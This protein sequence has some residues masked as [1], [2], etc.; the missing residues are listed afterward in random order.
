[1][2]KLFW[3]ITKYAMRH[4]ML[5]FVAY[6][7]MTGGIVSLLVILRLL[8]NA[9]DTTV[10]SGS[11]SQL[12]IQ[13]A[14]IVLAAGARGALTYIDEYSS[15]V[16]NQRVGREI[17]NDIFQKLQSLSYGFHDRQRTGD[18]MSRATV[19]VESVQ[20]F[21]M[22]GLGYFAYLIILVG[23]ASVLMLTMNLILGT[24]TMAFMA[25]VVWRSAA[26]VPSMVGLY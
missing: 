1:M 20:T 15:D 9:I 4:K 18:L 2:L 3:R 21:P 25:F 14:L 11:R 23:T 10:E 19:D 24:T 13:A 6:A 8:G 7:S 12:L 22:W 5:S 17:R 16:V 26:M